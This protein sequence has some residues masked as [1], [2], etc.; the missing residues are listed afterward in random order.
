M[1][2]GIDSQSWTRGNWVSSA[3]HERARM[4]ECESKY[5]R[6]RRRLKHPL[7]SVS[8]IQRAPTCDRQNLVPDECSRF[9]LM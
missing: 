7:S 6:A 8:V 5:E 3:V 9:V 4:T 2:R 1:Q